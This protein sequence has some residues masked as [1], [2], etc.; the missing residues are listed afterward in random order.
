MRYK[1]TCLE[2]LIKASGYYWVSCK[3]AKQHKTANRAKTANQELKED[4]GGNFAVIYVWGR[5][6][7]AVVSSVDFGGYPDF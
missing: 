1:N 5:R 4:L 7:L 3:N 2:T 6:H